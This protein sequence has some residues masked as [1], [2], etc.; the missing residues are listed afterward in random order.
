MSEVLCPE[1]ITKITRLNA[2]E[3]FLR[4]LPVNGASNDSSL[5]GG[6]KEM[7]TLMTE[8]ETRLRRGAL[9]SKLPGKTE[10]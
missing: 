10:H 3:R 2:D 4:R 5:E 6:W 9:V 1:E 7:L 8:S